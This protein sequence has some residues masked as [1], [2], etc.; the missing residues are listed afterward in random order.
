MIGHITKKGNKY[1]VVVPITDPTTGEKKNKWFSGYKNKREAEAAR[2]EI[3]SKLNNNTFV[4]PKKLT[5]KDYL[6]EWLKVYVEPNLSPTTTRGYRV[7]IEHHIIP[8]LGGIPLQQLKASNIQ[9]L[10]NSLKESGKVNGEGGLS[11]RSVRYVHRVLREAL[12]HAVQ[13]QLIPRNIADDLA[14]PQTKKYRPKVYTGEGIVK[15]LASVIDTE[16]ETPIHLAALLGLRR[17]EVLGLQWCDVDFKNNCITIQRQLIPTPKGNIFKEPK[18]EDSV[19]SIQLSQRL[20]DVLKKERKKQLRNKLIL[21]EKFVDNNLVCC[22][23]NG[24]MFSPSGFSHRFSELLK[25][26]GLEHIRFHDLRHSVATAMLNANIPIK[27]ASEILGHSNTSITMDLYSHV[28]DKKQKEIVE[29]LDQAIFG[30]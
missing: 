9:S 22:H 10:Y 24:E 8:Y 27:H 28:I 23:E 17:G 4:Q 5:V 20:V 21:G 25:K 18:T 3:I 29:T 13:Q 12:Q 1:Y 19:R 7:N 15:L 26:N 16:Y 14:L 30:K 11:P 6:K 2:I